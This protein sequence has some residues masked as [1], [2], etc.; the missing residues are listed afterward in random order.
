M[1]APLAAAF[2]ALLATPAFAADVTIHD[3]WARPSPSPMMKAGAAYAV[4][5]NAGAADR[6]VAARSD[7]ADRVELHTHI[8]EGD[9]MRMR[10][11]PDIPVPAHGDVALKPGGYH[12]M[13]M[14]LRGPLTE[15]KNISVTFV[16]EKAGEITLSVPV[17]APPK[18]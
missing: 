5:E 2:A 3:A 14:E 4:I 12:V 1:R 15:G 9:I 11:V 17:G 18:P 13:L 8:R 7:A 6:L 16:F 10:Q